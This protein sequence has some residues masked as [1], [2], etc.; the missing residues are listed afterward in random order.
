MCQRLLTKNVLSP[1]DR[2]HT[3]NGVRM[4]RRADSHR[5]DLVIHLI[6]HLAKI[7]VHFGAGIWGLLSVGIFAD[8]TYG[9]SGLIAGEWGQI[10]LQLIDIAALIVWVAP[11]V[12]VL[13]WLLKKSVGLRASREEELKGLDIPEHGLEAYPAEEPVKA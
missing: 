12:F 10:V 2:I 8:G 5:I 3:R 4:V 1:S 7:L 6:Q 9:V 11:T 13:F